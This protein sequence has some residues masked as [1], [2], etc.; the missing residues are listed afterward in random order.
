MDRRKRRRPPVAHSEPFA[1]V[2]A[3]NEPEGLSVFGLPAEILCDVEAAADVEEGRGLVPCWG[4]ENDLADRWD[5]RLLLDPITLAGTSLH[6]RHS[7]QQQQGLPA[8]VLAEEEAAGLAAE[9]T[10]REELDFE[11]YRDLDP[12]R[13]HELQ[14]HGRLMPLAGYGAG[15]RRP[16]GDGSSWERQAGLAHGAA[17]RYRAALPPPQLPPPHRGPPSGSAAIPFHYGAGVQEGAEVEDGSGLGSYAAIGFQYSQQELQQ[18]AEEEEAAAQEAAAA[19]QQQQ[20]QQQAAQHAAE[21]AAQLSDLPFVPPFVV[22]EHLREHLPATLRQYRMIRQ[23][24]AFVR[25]SGQQAEVLLR[26]RRAADPTFAFL[27]PHSTLHPFYRWL[28][29]ANPAEVSSAPGEDELPPPAADV[30]AADIPAAAGLPAAADAEQQPR[31]TQQPAQLKAQEAAQE[32]EEGGLTGQT[33]QAEFGPALPP[34]PDALQLLGQYGDSWRHRQ[35]RRAATAA[36]QAAQQQQQEQQGSPVQ[37]QQQQPQQQQAPEAQQREEAEGERKQREERGAEQGE[38]GGVPPLAPSGMPLETWLTMQKLAAFVHKNGAAFEGVVRA[39]EA[40][41]P[42]FAFL[43]ANHRHHRHYRQLLVESLGQEEAEALLA[44]AAAAVEDAEAQHL[45]AVLVRSAVAAAIANAEVQAAAAAAGTEG[46]SDGGQ[47]QGA[48]PWRA[49]FFFRGSAAA[50]ASAASPAPA[51]PAAAAALGGAADVPGAAGPPWLLGKRDPVA[52]AAPA[53]LNLRSNPSIAGKVLA[54]QQAASAAGAADAAATAPAAVVAP[55]AGEDTAA[56]GNA[57]PAQPQQQQPEVNEEEE[58]RLQQQADEQRATAAAAAA[59]AARAAEEAARLQAEQEEEARKAERRRRARELLAQRQQQQAAEVARQRQQNLAEV[60]QHRRAF[61]AES[62]GG[63][64]EGQEARAAAAAAAA[65]VAAAAVAAPP[66]ETLEALALRLRLRREAARE[67]LAMGGVSAPADAPQQRQQQQQQQQRAGQLTLPAAVHQQHK[68]ALPAHS[69]EAAASTAPASATMFGVGAAAPA[70]AAGGS[71]LQSI[72]DRIAAARAGGG[73]MLSTDA[74][75][76][77]AERPPSRG[78]HSNHRPA[79]TESSSGCEAAGDLRALLSELSRQAPP[80]HD[81]VI[82]LSLLERAYRWRHTIAAAEGGG[83]TALLPADFKIAGEQLSRIAGRLAAAWAALPSPPCILSVK[84]WQLRCIAACVVAEGCASVIDAPSLPPATVLAFCRCVSLLL[85]PGRLLL[86]HFT[87]D[88]C[89]AGTELPQATAVLHTQLELVDLLVMSFVPFDQNVLEQWTAQLA[90]PPA[91]V[92]WLEAATAAAASLPSPGPSVAAEVKAELMAILA[93]VVV[94]F[95]TAKECKPYAAVIARSDLPTNLVTLLV[96]AFHQAAVV[97]RLPPERR[98]QWGWCT[99]PF[100]AD[101]ASLLS[102]NGL[103]G[104][105]KAHLCP[106]AQ[107]SD[108][109]SRTG[110]VSSNAQ[111]MLATACQLMVHV[112]L[113]LADNPPPILGIKLRTFALL[114]GDVCL[115]I[116]A[117]LP[118]PMQQRLAGQFHMGYHRLAQQLAQV[119]PGLPATLQPLV[120]GGPLQHDAVCMVEVS[121]GWC[122]AVGLLQALLAS[123]P[124]VV[125]SWSEVAAWC[126]ACS[127]LLR[128]RALTA[129]LIGHYH[130]Q[131]AAHSAVSKLE[132]LLRDSPCLVAAA[133]TFAEQH[134]LSGVGAPLPAA[135]AA[136]AGTALWDLHT[137]L[138]RSAHQQPAGNVDH[139]W[140]LYL[141]STNRTLLAAWRLHCCAQRDGSQPFGRH[142]AAMAAAHCQFLQAFVC[143]A[144]HV[145]AV[146]HLGPAQHVASA[147]AVCGAMCPAVL[148]LHPALV[149][150]QCQALVLLAGKLS[151]KW[152]G[153]TPCI[154]QAAAASPHVT[155][156]MLA[157][158]AMEAML[159]LLESSGI[160]GAALLG[161]QDGVVA[162]LLADAYQ[163]LIHAADDVLAVASGGSTAATSEEL[164]AAQQSLKAVLS[165]LNA[166][167]GV[168]GRGQPSVSAASAA[169][170]LKMLREAAQPAAGQLASA[171]LVLWT[172]PEQW[173][174][175]AL[176]LAQA[177]AARSCAYLSCSNVCAEGGPAAGQGVGSKR[178]SQCHTAYYCGTDCSHADWRQGRH[179]RVCKALAGA[180]QADQ[181]QLPQC[182]LRPLLRFKVMSQT[183]NE[184]GALLSELSRQAPPSHDADIGLSLLMRAMHW[185]NSM[186]S[187]VQAGGPLLPPSDLRTAGEQL[188]RIAGRLAA[189]WAALPSPLC[190]LSV[191]VWQSR[192][193]V[194]CVVAEGCATV[195]DAASLPPA[196]VLAFC[197]C[198]SLLLGPGRL[199]LNNLSADSGVPAAELTVAAAMVLQA[200]LGM[201]TRM[202]QR[203]LESDPSVREQWMAQLA[204]PPAMVTWLEAAASAAA[205]LPLPGSSQT[206]EE[207]A[208]VIV[209]LASVVVRLVR[210]TDCS[211]YAAAIARSDTLPAKMLSLLVPAIH[212]AAVVLRLPPERRSQW[213]WCTWYYAA[214]MAG[215][216]SSDGLAEALKAHLCPPAQP[217]DDGSRTG[218]FSSSAQRLLATACQL[219]VHA[220][221][222]MTD[223]TALMV[224]TLLRGFVGLLGEMCS[225]IRAALPE[226]M[227]QQL[228]G[229]FHM[230]YHRLAQQLAQVLPRL[231]ATLQPLVE[232]GPLQHDAVCLVDVSGGWCHAVGLLQ[233]LLASCPTV[234]SSW[235][236]LAAW[237]TACAALLRGQALTAALV[238]QYESRPAEQGALSSLVTALRD[239]TCLIV[240][241]ATFAEQHKHCS[242]MAAAHCQV[243]QAVVCDAGRSEPVLQ[244]G[245]AQH[246]ASAIAVCGAMCP[247]VLVLYPAL[248]DLQRRALMVVNGE[249][250]E[251]SDKWTGMMLCMAQAAAVSPHVTA[252][253]LASGAM[254]AMLQLLE[255]S[256]AQGAALLGAQDGVVARLLC[257][258]YQ[259]L[260]HA[261]DDVLAVASGGS[262]AATSE[263]LQAAQQSLK[264]VLSGLNGELGVSG[265]GQS[266]VSAA[267]AAKVLREEA[268]PAAGQLA[269]ALLV[270]WTGPEQRKQAALELAQAS[271]ARSC[272]YLSCS[273][274]CVRTAAFPAVREMSQ[275]RA[276]L[277]DVLNE[278]SRPAGSFSNDEDTSQRL[279]TR[280]LDWRVTMTAAAEAGGGPL[281]SPA[282]FENAGEQLDKVAG[283][284]TAAWTARSSPAC[285][286]QDRV[287]RLRFS[288]AFVLAEGC[289]SVMDADSLPPA[290]GLAFCRCASLLLGPG[291]LLLD[292]FVAGGEA[293][294]GEPPGSTVDL[295]AQLRLMHVLYGCVS[296]CGQ[297]VCHQWTAQLAP[298]PSVLPR[299]PTTL[300]LLVEGGPLQHDTACVLSV[301]IGWWQPVALLQLLVAISQ[302]AW[303]IRPSSVSNWSEL[304]AWC[305]ACSALLKGRALTAAL[306]GQCKSQPSEQGALSSLKEMLRDS[307]CLAIEAAVFAEQQNVSE[308]SA[309]LPAA[310]VAAAEAALW[311]LHTALCRSAHQQPAGDVDHTWYLNLN[312]T[313]QTLLT[314]WRLHCCAQR[315]VSQPF[316]RHCAAMA[317][318]HCQFLQ[319]VVCDAGRSERVLQLGYAQHVA[320][321]IAVC[322]AMC[323][324]VL[325]L[326]PALVDLQCQALVLFAGK[327]SAEWFG[328]KLCIAQAAAASPHVTVHM[329]ASGAMETMLQQ[330]ERS[331]AQGVALLGAQVEAVAALLADAYQALVHAADDVLAAASDGS[332]AARTEELQA[333]QQSLKAVL[334]GLI[335]DLSVAAGGQPRVSAAAK[336]LRK[337]AQPAAGQLAAALLVLWTGPEQRK[338][339]ALELAQASAA[340]SCAYLSCSNVCGEGGPAAGQGVGSK[341]CSQC[342]T[343]YYCGTACSH[344][345]WRQGRHGRVCKALAGARQADEQQSHLDPLSIPALSA[346]AGQSLPSSRDRVVAKAVPFAQLA[347]DA[348]AT[349]VPLVEELLKLSSVEAAAWHSLRLLAFLGALALVGTLLLRALGR[350]GGR[351]VHDSS[352]TGRFSV[353]G[354]ILA[355]AFRPCKV[356]MPLYCGTRAATVVLA[357]AEVAATKGGVDPAALLCCHMDQKLLRALGWLTL[358]AGGD[359]RQLELLAAMKGATQLMQDCSE[360]VLIVAAA[361]TLLEFKGRV[362]S[363]AVSRLQTDTDPHNDGAVPL[364]RLLSAV[365]TVAVVMAAT[366]FTLSGFGFHI[367]PLLASVGGVGV[368]VGLATQDLLSNIAAAVSLYSTRPFVT[369]DHVVLVNQ[370]GVEVSGTV[371]NIEPTRTILLDDKN[372]CIVH[373]SNNGITDYIVRN[374]T[375]SRKLSR[376]Q[377]LQ[378]ASAIGRG[379][380]T[381][382]LVLAIRAGGADEVAAN[383]TASQD[384]AVECGSGSDGYGAAGGS[385][386][387]FST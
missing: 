207:Q 296:Q 320:S 32:E 87:A 138:C 139:T 31:Q 175:A 172:G 120:E 3:T 134:K 112:P 95:V 278:L 183:R 144:G 128:G 378:A 18:E 48:A 10:S 288:T 361:W 222:D 375:Q 272:A 295:H 150:L 156:H 224:G 161:A 384:Q 168:S 41:N 334:S 7:Q 165:S 184:L 154:A 345:D 301:S 187:A 130:S 124:T 181:Q 261:A 328:M 219:M 252:S 20:Q 229:Q 86:K 118:E 102:S 42:R 234:V 279:M 197:R 237:C 167:L 283:K 149:D 51:A 273:N 155:A 188:S 270:L 173:K 16:R 35:Q 256:G 80:S 135:T 46:S 104:A 266:S 136:A 199:L 341:R 249:N 326:Y 363:W 14:Q 99:W 344:A 54:R 352:L 145:E 88:V 202:L 53:K 383:T 192:C 79:S 346:L 76:A 193:I 354:S 83:G 381:Q 287:W 284:L 117:A 385:G 55:A 215:I 357:L 137:A 335:A 342:H 58:A 265:G 366:A 330:L 59:E 239:S 200:Q 245:H 327:L 337:E 376:L 100:A 373:I 220:P 238:G 185:R 30:P 313:N 365:L 243:L 258:A 310:I 250:S 107:P 371:L 246:V 240:A 23:T 276:E 372:G 198:V 364:L 132:D 322:G 142:C 267:A 146:L 214:D 349:G 351:R 82:G 8:T 157:S 186:I 94:P 348:E 218:A 36:E 350:A 160:Q 19:Q 204:P 353:W 264:A 22:P 143:D 206:A 367:G 280:A 323:P 302:S 290:T 26:V 122:Q 77:A 210:P 387:A 147:V 370:E 33:M 103:A 125:S 356:M 178:C 106:P 98:P 325:A 277:R 78:L 232:G 231:P 329:L 209:Q 377:E 66:I 153:M 292:H 315:D 72:R 12:A 309:P 129:A 294:G 29:Q 61:L 105:L 113:D 340:R 217:S 75:P 133:A 303:V 191:K 49:P 93:S 247:A 64:A 368:V 298:P 131:P 268:Q 179:G 170:M 194:A 374:Y 65:A 205:G 339:A 81:A 92:A 291:R 360:L 208:K 174:Q 158:G 119:L 13:E 140:Y 307:A 297:S 382:E 255:G 300:Q 171:L 28:L 17:G 347:A 299:L 108:N 336:M 248:L 362:I 230:D 159:Q 5:A 221:L 331:R 97:L 203:V 56:A 152:T 116:R 2:Q 4:N 62:E 1:G 21:A 11:R 380:T 289:A 121:S 319:A 85:G 359:S 169:S 126:T 259:A 212:Q 180:R 274:V 123:C 242:A 355:A 196:T 25:G 43:H 216:L 306:V 163:A 68:A 96:P 74:E 84:V 90:P 57:S 281:L 67:G 9:G 286:V 45:A 223:E 338:Q 47:T 254:E 39:R 262:T 151:D 257:D 15:F 176:E 225:H 269:S 226:P 50:A 182:A 115:H 195:I 109:G 263:E 343:A 89:V 6:R 69:L 71:N 321:A 244:L 177:S 166:D 386:V 251:L 60:A 379:R 24:A 236:E 304:A 317:A 189:A 271:A 91:V 316:G 308:F 333:A 111:R 227:Q 110:A 318:A 293:P 314:A 275:L 38:E 312:S 63:T 201:M 162:R 311:D 37:Q 213:G 369:N 282:D 332:T 305:T 190:I 52:A 44:A 164:Q 228:A 324:A 141:D 260:V 233:A 253:M 358:A 34:P 235:S 73:A 114:L 70:S 127:A 27:E 211:P 101:M 40:R 148:V 241:A 285:V